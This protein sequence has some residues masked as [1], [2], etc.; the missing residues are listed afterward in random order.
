MNN[1]RYAYTP[2]EIQSLADEMLRNIDREKVRGFH[3]WQFSGSAALSDTTLL[4]ATTKQWRGY[5]V[6]LRHFTDEPPRYRHQL[7]H[8]TL[9][10]TTQSYS[11]KA[12]IEAIEKLLKKEAQ[13]HEKGESAKSSRI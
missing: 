6:E 2:Q 13:R 7:K 3:P 12:L 1:T 4:V 10:S 8:L 5:I 11:R 9:R